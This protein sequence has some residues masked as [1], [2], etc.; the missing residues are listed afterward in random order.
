MKV[1]FNFK[2]KILV[3]LLFLGSNCLFSQKTKL[4]ITVSAHRP[5]LN[6]D[7]LEV[8]LLKTPKTTYTDHFL[9]YKH[10]HLQALSLYRRKYTHQPV[11]YRKDE[12]NPVRK[13]IFSF[14][15]AWAHFLN[16]QIINL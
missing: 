14:L 4:Q 9:K 10:A 3:F 15:L 5:V 1:L 8:L 12:I 2:N 11:S 7:S 16:T 6:L 13:A